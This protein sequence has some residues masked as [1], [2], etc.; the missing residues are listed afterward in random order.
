MLAHPSTYKTQNEIEKERVLKAEQHCTNKDNLLRR[1]F[2]DVGVQH[3]AAE[4]EICSEAE[5]S[6]YPIFLESGLDLT[7]EKALHY[8]LSVIWMK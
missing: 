7:V 5:E 2:S 1:P 6:L 8:Y 4:I 3:G